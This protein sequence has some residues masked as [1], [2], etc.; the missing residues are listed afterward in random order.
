MDI[1]QRVVVYQLDTLKRVH[2]DTLCADSL[3][4][5]YAFVS[6]KYG[7]FIVFR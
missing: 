5:G 1:V 7:L 3:G 2:L 6:E 4:V